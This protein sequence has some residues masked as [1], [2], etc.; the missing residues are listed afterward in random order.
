MFSTLIFVLETK[1]NSSEMP[2]PRLCY[3]GLMCPLRVDG[4]RRLSY[5]GS[6]GKS[7]VSV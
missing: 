5:I 6:K 3:I 7:K 4:I 1:I 2:I